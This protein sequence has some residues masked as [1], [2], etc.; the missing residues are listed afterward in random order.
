MLFENEKPEPYC[1][2][3]CNKKNNMV[4]VG[5]DYSLS[6]NYYVGEYYSGQIKWSSADGINILKKIKDK[7]DKESEIVYSPIKAGNH[8]ISASLISNEDEIVCEDSIIIQSKDKR[9]INNIYKFLNHIGFSQFY[10]VLLTF[11]IYGNYYLL[12]ILTNI[13]NSAPIL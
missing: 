3:I 10:G 12:G 1:E 7:Q 13:I 2:L 5:K 4:E 9:I 8:K 6:V 11:F